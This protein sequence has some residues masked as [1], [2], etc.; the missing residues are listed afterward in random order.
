MAW[1]RA[2]AAAPTTALTALHPPRLSLLMRPLLP[3]RRARPAITS[4]GEDM[5][6]E[7]GEKKRRKKNLLEGQ[8]EDVAAA[9]GDAALSS[10]ITASPPV[11][12]FTATFC[13]YQ[14]ANKLYSLDAYD[15]FSCHTLSMSL[16]SSRRRWLTDANLYHW[17]L[18]HLAS[19]GD[20]TIS[21]SLCRS[22]RSPPPFPFPFPFFLFSSVL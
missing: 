6:A 9:V 17:D 22:N 20:T 21:S 11:R 19:V 2:L 18:K 8:R 1:I 16:I 3:T 5:D 13:L 14:L 7:M 12:N 10:I 4:S 15:N